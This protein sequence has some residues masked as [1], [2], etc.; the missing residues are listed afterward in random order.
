MKTIA[1]ETNPKCTIM[2]GIIANKFGG[3][4]VKHHEAKKTKTNITEAEK[5]SKEGKEQNNG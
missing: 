3:S 1:A 2:Y 4:N 5:T